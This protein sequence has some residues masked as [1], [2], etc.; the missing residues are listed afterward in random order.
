MPVKLGFRVAGEEHEQRGAVVLQ[1]QL[2]LATCNVI[3][4]WLD[5]HEK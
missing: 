4:N 3:P 1:D 5:L 2:T